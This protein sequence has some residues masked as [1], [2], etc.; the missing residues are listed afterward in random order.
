V[1]AVGAF[2][3][4]AA[5]TQTHDKPYASDPQAEAL[6]QKILGFMVA[7]SNGAA[8]NQQKAIGPSEIGHPCPRNVAFKVAGVDKQPSWN[9]PFPSILGVAFHAWME[10]N[11]PADE[12]IP[13]RRVHVTSTLSG[14][15]DAYH[16]PT[17]TVVDWKLLGRTQHQAWLGGY[18][19]EQYEVQADSYGLGFLNAGFPVDRVAIAV[20][21]RA[22]PLQDMF[23]WSRAWNPANAQKALNRLAMI[24][25]YV[26]ASGASN[27]NRAPL[28]NIS[29]VSGDGCFFCPFKGSAAQGLCDKSK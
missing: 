15:S 21:C 10:A 13:E 3:P 26:G 23:L 28:M 8:R 5:N 25:T 1:T 29:P 12:W 14:S 17:R 18:S 4:K 27:T 19:S 6:R 16:I 9:D 22:K 24:R 7:A 2:V 11:L 20:F